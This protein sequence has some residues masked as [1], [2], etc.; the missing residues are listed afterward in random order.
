VFIVLR[1]ICHSI[2]EKHEDVCSR[3]AKNKIENFLGDGFK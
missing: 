2:G 3:Y 1:E